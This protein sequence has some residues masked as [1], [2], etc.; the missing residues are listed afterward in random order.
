MTQLAEEATARLAAA[1][2]VQDSGDMKEEGE[3]GDKE[4]E[5]E[6]K[7]GEVKEQVGPLSLAGESGGEIL[8]MRTL[9]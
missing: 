5:A 1:N 3:T 8:R 2:D 7:D 9:Y 4:Q 6:E